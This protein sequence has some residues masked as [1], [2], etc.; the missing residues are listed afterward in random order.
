MEIN[1]EELRT[2]II[3]CVENIFDEVDKSGIDKKRGTNDDGDEFVRYNWSMSI[4]DEKD[5]DTFIGNI[6]VTMKAL[7]EVGRHSWNGAFYGAKN[8]PSITLQWRTFPEFVIDDNTVRCHFRLF[9]KLKP[10]DS[11]RNMQS[12]KRR[13]TD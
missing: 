1:L 9:V 5:I 3:I 4:F 10:Y 13:I 7:V 11:G 8:R 12:F 6:R 2:K